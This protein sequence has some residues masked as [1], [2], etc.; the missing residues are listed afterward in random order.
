MLAQ[1]RGSSESRV[2][3][4]QFYA[5]CV[6]TVIPVFLWESLKN[7]SKTCPTPCKDTDNKR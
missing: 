2:G 3:T 5:L 4:H 7:S 6:W 1:S